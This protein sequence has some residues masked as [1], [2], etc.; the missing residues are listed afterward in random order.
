MLRALDETSAAVGR[1][2]GRVSELVFVG[3][4]LGAGYIGPTYEGQPLNVMELAQRVGLADHGAIVALA[5]SVAVRMDLSVAYEHKYH[6]FATREY[7]DWLDSGK[8][9][10]AR[11]S[12]SIYQ[13]AGRFALP[14]QTQYPELSNVVG[15]R[16]ALL[17]IQ[18][19]LLQ[20]L[21]RTAM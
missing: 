5:C 7:V 1:D 18:E 14:E 2:N 8:V 21:Q 17:T 13:P 16:M 19:A 15:P 9:K 6:V 20:A 11:Q 4:G 10:F 3:H 12:R